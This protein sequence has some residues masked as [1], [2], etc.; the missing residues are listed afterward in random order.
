MTVPVG[1]GTRGPRP[2]T[3]PAAQEIRDGLAGARTTRG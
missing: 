1:G 3:G 2:T